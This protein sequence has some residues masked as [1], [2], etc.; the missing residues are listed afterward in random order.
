M[1]MNNRGE[2]GDIYLKFGHLKNSDKLFWTDRQT[3]IVY[4]MKFSNPGNLKTDVGYIFEPP[5]D[6]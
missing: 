1:N 5:G 2:E 6:L 4:Q 3:D